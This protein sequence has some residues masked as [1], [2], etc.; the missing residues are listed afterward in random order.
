M[1]YGTNGFRGDAEI[2]GRICFRLSLLVAIRA[3]VLGTMGIMVTG[4][5]EDQMVNG[6]KVLEPD[7]SI[8]NSDW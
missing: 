7:G 2:M 4:S 1:F 8:L 5:G 3:K 6:V